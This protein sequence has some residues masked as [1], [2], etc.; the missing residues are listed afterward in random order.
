M[1][2]L[3][4]YKC[5]ILDPTRKPRDPRPCQLQYLIAVEQVQKRFPLGLVPCQLDHHR[6]LLNIN[7]LGPEYICDGNHFPPLCCAG[8]NLHHDQLPVNGFTVLKN[9]DLNNILQ[10]ADLLFYLVQYQ[11]VSACNNRCLLYTS[12][13]HDLGALFCL[14]A[15]P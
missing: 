15:Y 11:F 8:T 12:L 6:F 5:D 1:Y 14:N 10:L 9:L 2:C 7:D 4:V 13:A 3:S